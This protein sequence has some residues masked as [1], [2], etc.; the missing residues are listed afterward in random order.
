MLCRANERFSDLSPRVLRQALV[1]ELIDY[2]VS[3]V[4]GHCGRFVATGE[5]RSAQ[6]ARLAPFLVGPS[7]QVAQQKA[8]LER[9]LYDRV[10]RHPRILHIREQA[11]S[12]LHKMFAGYVR[13]PGRL[14][15]RYLA[16]SES[17]G[18][19]RAVGEYIAGMTD[20]FCNEQF[21][22]YFH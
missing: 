11:Q 6:Q 9:F 20:R 14:P 3:D 16:R 2:Q 10:Y 1:H 4:L 8:E 21:E 15:K 5:L 7:E 12:R 22:Q 17:V 18:L 13:Q 19:P